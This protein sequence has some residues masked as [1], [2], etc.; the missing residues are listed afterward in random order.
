R[1]EDGSDDCLGAWSQRMR[2]RY[3]PN[4]VPDGFFSGDA[5]SDPR[6]GAPQDYYAWEW[7]DALFVVLDPFRY[8]IRGP[9]ASDGWGWSLGRAQYTWLSQTLEKSKAKFKFVFIHNLLTGDLA[10]RGGVEVAGFNEWGGKNKDGSDGFAEHRPGW[11]MPVHKL[12]VRN[13][14]SIVFK[15]H[16]NFFARQDLDGIVYQMVPQPSFA[17]DDRIRDL[18]TYGYKAGT[19]LGNSGHVRVRVDSEKVTVEYIR[20]SASGKVESRGSGAVAYS[21]SVPSRAH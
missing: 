5:V 21:F 6:F 16:D 2:T 17:G 9:G 10:A 13:H 3:F 18:A 11:E 14:V 7:G 15:A 20:A 19:F 12:L 4:P 8:S 1:Y